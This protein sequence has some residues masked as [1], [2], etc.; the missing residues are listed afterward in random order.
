LERIDALLPTKETAGMRRR[1]ER[2]STL[3][4]WRESLFSRSAEP[5]AEGAFYWTQMILFDMP[6]GEAGRIEAEWA[7][8]LARGF[9]VE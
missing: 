1:A 4:E 6:A 2:V 8:A 9:P 7:A 5:H 3:P